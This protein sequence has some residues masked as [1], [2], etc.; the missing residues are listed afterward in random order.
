MLAPAARAATAPHRPFCSGLT[1]APCAPR[2]A[3]RRPSAVKAIE[4]SGRAPA[5]LIDA[6]RCSAVAIAASAAV[7]LSGLPAAADMIEVRW[8]P[9]GWN[10]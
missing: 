5:G 9:P 4:Q 10:L 1:R 2:A 8:E 7:L 6:A 3:L